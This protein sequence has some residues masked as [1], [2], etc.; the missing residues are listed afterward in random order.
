[1]LQ[2]EGRAPVVCGVTAEPA[3][4]HGD[5]GAG[6]VC[7]SVS[8]YVC[9]FISGS[10]LHASHSLQRYEIHYNVCDPVSQL[11]IPLTSIPLCVCS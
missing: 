1:M 4:S 7:V 11:F 3:H 10:L 6:S 8:V 2:S 5:G 9:V